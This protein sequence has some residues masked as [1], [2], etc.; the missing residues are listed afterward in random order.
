MNAAGYDEVD[1][2]W[3]ALQH[4]RD[5]PVDALGVDE[6]VVVEDEVEPAR[7]SG[8]LVEEGCGQCLDLGGSGERSAPKTASPKPSSTAP[9]A[10]AR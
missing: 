10:V 1:A 3:K 4:E 7:Q 9:S 6:M 5:D 2:L 8:Q